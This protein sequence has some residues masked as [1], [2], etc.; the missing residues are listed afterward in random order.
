MYFTAATLNL[1]PFSRF[2]TTSNLTTNEDIKGAY[3]NKRTHTNFN[4]FSAGNAILNCHD[5]LCGPINPSLIDARGY[6]TEDYL[7]SMS[8][9]LTSPQ[10]PQQQPPVLPQV[11]QQPQVV[12]EAPNPS[13]TVINMA[14]ALD[15]QPRKM[16]NSATAPEIASSAT[17][18]SN[19]HKLP[20]IKSSSTAQNLSLT[21]TNIKAHNRGHVDEKLDLDQTTMIGSALDL[22]S[23]ESAGEDEDVAKEQTTAT[24]SSHAGSQVGLLKLSAV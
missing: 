20:A 3:S 21:T 22:D 12:Q 2:L 4:P 19:K 1:C 11:V 8:S 13:S 10:Q 7:V 15:P 16:V 5:V 17:A 9:S 23:L 14:P 24:G 6:V 18:K